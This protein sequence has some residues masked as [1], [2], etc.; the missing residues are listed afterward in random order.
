MGPILNS[1]FIKNKL[2]LMLIINLKVAF[3]Q[4]TAKS[5]YH[6]TRIDDSHAALDMDLIS[7]YAD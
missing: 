1:K 4:K 2:K 7:F 6:T 3:V 5:T